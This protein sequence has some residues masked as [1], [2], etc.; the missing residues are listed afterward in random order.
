MKGKI[1][2]QMKGKENKTCQYSINPPKSKWFD[3]FVDNG[4]LSF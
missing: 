3:Y 1:K 2:G 4:I